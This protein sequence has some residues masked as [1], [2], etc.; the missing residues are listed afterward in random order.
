MKDSHLFHIG[1]HMTKGTSGGAE[2]FSGAP[3]LQTVSPQGRRDFVQSPE[4]VTGN[5][6]G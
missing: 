2:G 6:V 5:A 4:Q 3:P 1:Q